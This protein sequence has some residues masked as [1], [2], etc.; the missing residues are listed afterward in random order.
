MGTRITK[1]Q[2]S[3]TLMSRSF[4]ADK[5]LNQPAGAGPASGGA[6]TLAR[7]IV[8]G[9]TMAAGRGEKKTSQH[10]HSSGA[11]QRCLGVRGAG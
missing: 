5:T 1:S 4:A 11:Q 7:A 6:A 10:K 2:S 9:P 8:F 3:K